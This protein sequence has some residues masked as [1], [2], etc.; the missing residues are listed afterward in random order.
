MAFGFAEVDHA[1][2]PGRLRAPDRGGRVTGLGRRRGRRFRR[3]PCEQD[4]EQRR[5]DDQQH[6]D[7]L[8]APAPVDHGGEALECCAARAPTIAGR[9]ANRTSRGRTPRIAAGLATA[10][11]ACV[12]GAC[13]GSGAQGTTRT[14]VRSAQPVRHLPLPP[15]LITRA[16]GPLGLRWQTVA[17]T[18][19]YP[20]VW[21]AEREGVTLMRIDQRY[22]HLDL[23]AGS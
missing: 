3:V 14:T 15:A 12:L 7:H 8:Y 21:V 1:A 10:L 4:D 5:D 18:R 22:A 11:V 6:H 13:G 16:P 19:G 9:M 20:S 17:W 23:H 2:W